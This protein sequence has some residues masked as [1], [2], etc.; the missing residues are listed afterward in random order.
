[1]GCRFGRSHGRGAVCRGRGQRATRQEP[2]PRGGQ[3]GDVVKGRPGRGAAK[4]RWLRQSGQDATG[5]T[6]E[7]EKGGGVDGEEESFMGKK[8]FGV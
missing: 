1:M 8:C 4:G 3:A 6:V 5:R 7:E 2:W